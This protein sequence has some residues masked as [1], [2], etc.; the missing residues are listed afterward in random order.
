MRDAIFASARYSIRRTDSY[1]MPN[2]SPTCCCVNNGSSCLL[3][4]RP[5][6]ICC[7]KA[8]E[9]WVVFFM[10]PPIQFRSRALILNTLAAITQLA[11]RN[12]DW[13]PVARSVH[14]E[15]AR[16]NLPPRCYTRRLR[17]RESRARSLTPLDESAI[18]RLGWVERNVPGY[19]F[20]PTVGA[21][22][23]HHNLLYVFAR[24]DRDNF[25]NLLFSYYG[26]IA[27][28]NLTLSP[29]ACQIFILLLAQYLNRAD[30]QRL[31]RLGL[32][33]ARSF[34][35]RWLHIFKSPSLRQSRFENFCVR[36][37]CICV[38]TVPDAS[39]TR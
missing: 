36:R 8:A 1:E 9:F 19:R 24:T 37:R 6:S 14:N 22:V 7:R 28:A 32:F 27:I 31:R 3:M 17:R 15:C 2:L 29:I 39:S 30:F 5:I 11:C 33:Y 12:T 20:F 38:S 25:H 35:F 16:R 23:V 21:N 13:S 4:R 34:Y 10:Q 18:H 26:F